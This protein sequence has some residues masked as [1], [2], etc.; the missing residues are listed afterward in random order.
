MKNL[1]VLILLTFILIGCS[2]R[3]VGYESYGKPL[4]PSTTKS[5]DNLF[6]YSNEMPSSSTQ[7]DEQREE[8]SPITQASLEENAVNKIA[9]VFPSKIVGKYATGAINTVLSQMLFNNI[10]FNL[11]VIDT[12]DESAANIE[13]AINELHEKK[14]KKVLMFITNAG[15]SSIEN[16][17]KAKEFT[18]YAPLIHQKNSISSMPNIVYG[19]IDYE[20]QVEALFQYS[21]HKDVVFSAQTMLGSSLKDLVLQ[22]SQRVAL[23]TVVDSQTNNYKP[24]VTNRNIS[25]STL[26]MN[27]S[28]VQ[29]AILL[30][31]LRANE[32]KPHIILSTQLNYTPMIISLT[33]YLDRKDFL[34]ANSIE[35]VHPNLEEVNALLDTDIVY[36]WVNYSTLI[37]INYLLQ[38][39][40]LSVNKIVNNQVQYKTTIYKNTP[41]GFEKYPN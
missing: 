34:I 21:N 6:D 9:I 7:R 32:I 2:R 20:Q 16:N 23:N 37:G 29:T 3:E 22:K 14:Y 35:A 25:G 8:F 30:S 18:I 41:Y 33:Q 13:K 11:E 24:L 26:F 10:S 40:E 12:F 5:F 28:I 36:N 17:E 27:T 15:L 39:E 38:N 31:Q 4:E 1:V 19:G